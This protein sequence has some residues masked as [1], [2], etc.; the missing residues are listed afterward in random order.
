MNYPH[1]IQLGAC[2]EKEVLYELK[3]YFFCK[4][5]NCLFEHLEG[6]NIFINVEIVIPSKAGDSAVTI[7]RNLFQKNGQ[8]K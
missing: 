7:F 1:V 5:F 3:A 2:A 4:I 8:A 6:I